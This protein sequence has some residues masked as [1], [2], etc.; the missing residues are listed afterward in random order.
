[1]PHTVQAKQLSFAWSH[2]RG[3]TPAARPYLLVTYFEGDLVRGFLLDEVPQR[4]VEF[5]VYW[6]T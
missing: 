6:P 4:M 3:L 1:M 5:V 2:W